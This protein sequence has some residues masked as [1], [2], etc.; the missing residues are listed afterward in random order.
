MR[1]TAWMLAWLGLAPGAA[2]M[3]TGCGTAYDEFF[4]PLSELSEGASGG[5]G[6]N[7]ACAGEPN[8]VN[9]TEE[10]GVFA[11]ADAM[12][13]SDAGTREK[14][15]TTLQAAIEA[16][17]K[18]TG[19]VYACSSAPFLETVTVAAGVEI[20]GGFDCASSWAWK[21]DAKSELT[22][23]ADA[24]ALTV[25]SEAVGLM[26]KNFTIAAPSATIKGGSS[27]AV[28]V[29]DV[30]ASFVRCEVKAGDGLDGEDGALPT[31]AAAKGQDAPPSDPTKTNACISGVVAGGVSGVTMCEE[32]STAGGLGG[33][34]GVQGPNL[35]GL[36]GASGAPLTAAGGG[37]GTGATAT[38]ACIDGGKGKDGD[39]GTH[40]AAGPANTSADKLSLTG[41]SGGDGSDG[42]TGKAGQGGGGGGGATAG[43]FCT[44]AGSPTPGN[45][46][47][48][49]GGGAG[50]C[51]GKGGGG[52]KAGGS[53]IAIVSM[54]AGLTLTDVTLS[55]GKGGKGGNGTAGFAGGGAGKGAAGGAAS[56]FSGSKPGCQGGNGGL[57]GDG[58]AGGGG[59]GGHTVGVGFAISPSAPLEVTLAAPGTPGAGGKAGIN[60]PMTSNGS[61]G[62]TG[63]CW[64]FSKNV[65]CSK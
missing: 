40:G 46:A 28:V 45:G 30:E 21:A 64:D 49:G 7:L 56:G 10:C 24:I 54:G 17:A 44:S 16:A 33:K 53:S 60:A 29:D 2:V 34:G 57:G 36:K 38:T 11:R 20:Y 6:G 27:I 59:R 48:G 51:G 13:A 43:T 4:R 37:G 1:R 63:S 35:N 62:W 61:S 32:G 50:G 18:T 22:G 12:G 15:Y 9:T 23:P 14:P 26:I 65:S 42:S 58:G 8:A 25:T 39:T 3:F 55:L 5:S 41:L 52:G 19:R 47:S 31:G